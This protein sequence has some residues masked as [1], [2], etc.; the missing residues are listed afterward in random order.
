MKLEIW[1]RSPYLELM[2]MHSKQLPISR[3]Y[4]YLINLY[5]DLQRALSGR[6]QSKSVRSVVCSTSMTRVLN[7]FCSLAFWLS[8]ELCR[9]PSYIWMIFHHGPLVMAVFIPLLPF[10]KFINQN[11]RNFRVCKTPLHLSPVATA[12]STVDRVIWLWSSV[13]CALYS[14]LPTWTSHG[15]VTPYA[16]AYTI[17]VCVVLRCCTVPNLM[18]PVIIRRALNPRVIRCESVNTSELFNHG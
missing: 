16:K 1:T 10:S 15:V 18:G 5:D 14:Y 3:S 8:F 7:I 6:L 9:M 17:C 11:L 12:V 4:Q 2:I 13:C